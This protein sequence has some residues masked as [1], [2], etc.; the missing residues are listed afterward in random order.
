MKKGEH[1]A[2]DIIKDEREQLVE[3]IIEHLEKG[4]APWQKPWEAKSGIPYNP[5]TDSKYKGI[6]SLK[7]TVLSMEKGYEDSRWVTFKQAQDKEWSVKKGEKGTRIEFFRLYDKSTKKD[8]DMGMYNQLNSKEK[9][10]YSQKNVSVVS[11]YYTVFNGSQIDGIPE[12]KLEKPELNGKK[13]EALEKIISN[14][15][16]PIFY[17]GGDRAFYSLEK[18]SIHLPKRENFRS[19]EDFY[20]TALHEMAHSTGHPDRM[21]REMGGKF[22]SEKYAKEELRA[23][24]ASMFIAQEKGIPLSK[25]H[26]ENHSSYVASWIKVLKEDHNELFRAAKEASGISDRILGLE[27]GKEQTKAVASKEKSL[28]KEKGKGIEL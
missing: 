1:S 3:K 4:T 16:A 5:V 19:P 21:N 11:Q 27:I 18:D 12:L 9:E 6:N 15:E 13:V 20:S 24:I 8:L 2:K 22:G 14:S 28:I 10:A 26:I 7:L 23:E 17:N 25:E